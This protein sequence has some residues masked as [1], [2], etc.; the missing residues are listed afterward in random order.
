MI[1]P[2]QSLNFLP[3]TNEFHPN[4]GPRFRNC[5]IFAT[6]TSLFPRFYST[7]IQL[8]TMVLDESARKRRSLFYTPSSF[9]N[10]WQQ[11]TARLNGSVRVCTSIFNRCVNRVY[12]FYGFRLYLVYVPPCVHYSLC[13]ICTLAFTLI[14]PQRF[15][16]R[17]HREVPAQFGIWRG[18]R[19]RLVHLWTFLSHSSGLCNLQLRVR[20]EGSRAHALS[21]PVICGYMQIAVKHI[22]RRNAWSQFRQCYNPRLAMHAQRL[23]AKSLTPWGFIY[24]LSSSLYAPSSTCFTPCDSTTKFLFNYISL[25]LSV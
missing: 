22:L 17:A 15:Y 9:P 21:L 25:S 23:V 8:S 1:K 2:I 24:V 4:V 16:I 18:D 20:W 3:I 12:S 19:V 13:T 6:V 10:P 14:L 11:P 5:I 7:Y